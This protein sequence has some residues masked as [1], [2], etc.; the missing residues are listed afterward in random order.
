MGLVTTL[1]YTFTQRS[2]VLSA[3]SKALLSMAAAVSVYT[4]TVGRARA[5]AELTRMGYHV[6]AKRL[7]LGEELS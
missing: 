1:T 6:E 5:A 7:M 2:R 3:L 4:E